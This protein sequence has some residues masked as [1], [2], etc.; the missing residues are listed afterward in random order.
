MVLT[1]FSLTT[2]IFLALI[3]VRGRRQFRAMAGAWREIV[4]TNLGTAMAW[5]SYFF[6]LKLLE[7]AVVNMLHMGIGP[8][9]LVLLNRA[10]LHIS[11]P[12]VVRKSELVIQGAIFLS[13]AALPGIVLL[14]LSR[15]GGRSLAENASGSPW[16]W[17]VA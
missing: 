10:G 11:G 13:L 6:A 1:A 7:P 5:L 8:V 14:E 15:L 2:A 12:A 16:P 4:L 9:A 17:P 3:A